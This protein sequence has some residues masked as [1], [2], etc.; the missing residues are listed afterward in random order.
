MCLVLAPFIV[1]AVWVFSSRET[2]VIPRERAPDLIGLF[3]DAWRTPT[4]EFR[5]TGGRMDGGIVRVFLAAPGRQVTMRLERVR[6]SEAV[7]PGDVVIEEPGS[8]I[9]VVWTCTPACD[10]S[11]HASVRSLA[12]RI[13]AAHPD[14]LW[15]RTQ[16]FAVGR[17]RVV[18]LALALAVYCVAG[19][20]GAVALGRAWPFSR[21]RLR[22]AV[23]VCVLCA[24]A[25]LLLGK[26]SVANWYSNNLPAVGGLLEADDRNGVAGFFLQAVIRAVLPWTDRTLFGLNLVLHAVAGGVFYLAF[27]ELL[28]RRDVALLALVLWALLPL[29][30]RIGWSDAQHVQV[31]LLFALLLLVWLRAQQSRCWPERML[32]PLLAAL[33]PFV[34][35]EAL[36]LAPLPLLFGVFVGDRPRVRRALDALAYCVLLAL[37]AAA[38]FQLFVQ[39][40]DQPAPQ[41]AAAIGALF[42]PHGYGELF[43]QFFFINSGRP[44]WFPLPA[45]VLLLIGVVTIAVRQPARLAALLAAFC[46]PQLL[47]GRLF[48]VEGMVSARYFLPLMALL[49]LVMADGVA[50]LADGLRCLIARYTDARSAAWAARAATVLGALTVLAASLPL[51]RYDYTFQEEYRFLRDALAMLPANARVLHLPAREDDQIHNDPDCCLDPGGSPLALAFPFAHFEPVP[52]DRRDLPEAVDG[53]TYYYE[54]ALCRLA[55]TPYSEGRNPGLSRTLRDLCAALAGDPR[56]DVIASARVSSNGVWPFLEPGD[57]PLRLYRIRSDR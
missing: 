44:N 18:A 38:F 54:G 37:S 31:E 46:V 57:V 45:T 19:L 28:I 41:L 9:R 35:P 48:N 14:H 5:I 50:A 21:E 7:A 15:V 47:L 22:D 27:R 1:L 23:L 2:L 30:L 32:A 13:L 3:G 52:L 10:A 49:A 8:E 40:Y 51:Y 4:G 43:H 39:H 11:A 34:R 33:L 26:W 56:L 6:A 12:Q 17:E 25:A 29:P 55:P 24:G 53:H 42:D 20:L 36:L 16:G